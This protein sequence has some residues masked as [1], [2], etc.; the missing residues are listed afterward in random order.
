[1]SSFV[2]KLPGLARRNSS[3]LLSYSNFNT[4]THFVYR[5]L[6]GLARTKI[7]AQR[8]NLFVK[9]VRFASVRT[10]LCPKF[11]AEMRRCG[12]EATVSRVFLLSAASPPG[13]CPTTMIIF[14]NGERPSR[15]HASVKAVGLF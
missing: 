13:S 6:F 3:M 9:R 2:N 11:V 8:A 5:H 14:I 12:R 10:Y 7:K 15:A 1:M 4:G